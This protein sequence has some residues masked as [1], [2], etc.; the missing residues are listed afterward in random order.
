MLITIDTLNLKEDQ[1]SGD[2]ALGTLLDGNGLH[3]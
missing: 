2:K 3:S 1:S